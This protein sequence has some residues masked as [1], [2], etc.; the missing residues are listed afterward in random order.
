MSGTKRLRRFHVAIR[1]ARDGGDRLSEH[2]RDTRDEDEHH[3]LRLVDAE[4]E[5]GQ[6]NQRGHWQI[7]AEQRER[8]GR[9]FHDA[10]RS[11]DDA[12]RHA[13]GD[14]EAESDQDAL[15]CGGDALKERAIVQE[16]RKTFHHFRR[17]RQNDRRDEAILRPEAAGGEPPE[18]HDDSYRAHADEAARH[19]GRGE[20]KRQERRCACTRSASRGG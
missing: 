8:R 20:S 12:E 19:R 3:F 7:A 17:A 2:E 4:P 9:G 16:A 13:D 11:R 18:K 1:H 5:N 10:P 6:R 14:G 15:E